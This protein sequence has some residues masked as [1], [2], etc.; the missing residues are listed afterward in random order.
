[1]FVGTA[2]TLAFF[3]ESVIIKRERTEPVADKDR[4]QDDKD[5]MQEW[6][7]AR[8]KLRWIAEGIMVAM[9]LATLAGCNDNMNMPSHDMSTE[10]E[11]Q[12]QVSEQIP[13][14][15]DTRLQ[16]EE[17][18]FPDQAWQK[19]VFFPD[20][21]GYVDN[22]LAMNGM[23]SFVGY[24]GQGSLYVTVAE[25]VTSFSMYV[26]HRE[27][28][29]D[30][31]T[32][33][34]S[35]RIDIADTVVN[36]RNTVQVAG[37]RPR[38][39]QSAVRVSVGYPEVLPG[40]PD[41]EGIA[42]ESLDLISDLIQSDIENGFTSAQLAVVRNGRLVY[43]NAWGS[44]NAY[45]P[46]GT[47]KTDSS[48]VTVDTLYDLASVTKMFSVNYALQKLV[49]DGAIGLDDCIADY[50]G[51]A[52][53]Q[54]VV[55]V[56]GSAGVDLATQKKWK[57]NLTIRELLQHQG[58]FPADPQ[59]FRPS[60][61]LFAGNDGSAETRAAT[62]RAICKTP[63]QY[64]P[65]TKTLYSDVDYM[66]LG[67]VVEKVTGQDLNTYLKE[68]FWEPM[69]LSHITYN[70]LQN[71]F[72]PDDCA[73]TELNGNSRDGYVQF[74][75]LRTETLQGQVHDEKAYYCMGGVSGHAGLFSNAS[76][77]AK[78]ASVMLTG[79]Y[80]GNRFF[81]QNVLDMFTSP[82][83]EDAANWGLGWWREGEDQRVWY[84]GT[85]SGS[86]TI[87]HQGWTGTV[88]MSDPDRSLVIVYLTNKINSP[89][90]DKENDPNKFN[91]S[92][93]TA[94]TLGFVPQILSV[95]MDV[96]TA[97][98]AEGQETAQAALHDQLSVLA[99]DMA[100]ESIKLLPDDV[101]VEHPAVKNVESKIALLAKWNEEDE[102]EEYRRLAAE[103][104]GEIAALKE[105]D[106]AAVER[107]LAVMTT[108]QKV[109]LMMVPALQT[110][111]TNDMADVTKRDQKLA[112]MLKEGAFGG[113][114]L[115]TQ[116]EENTVNT[117]NTENA[118]QTMKV[119]WSMRDWD[120]AEKAIDRMTMVKYFPVQKDVGTAGDAEFPTVDTSLE[121]LEAN[122]LSIFRNELRETDLILAEHIRYPQ[123]ETQTY[124]SRKNKEEITLPAS[125]S[126]TMINGLLRGEC[127]YGGV[128]MT[129][130]MNTPAIAAHFDQEDAAQ[131]AIEAGAD[132]LFMPVNVRTAKDVAE[133][134]RYI[135]RIVKM[136]EEGEISKE[137]MDESAR[138]ILMMK[139]RYGLLEETGAYTE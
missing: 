85:Q 42:K 115:I 106:M 101:W 90:T 16:A 95:G 125:L 94:S 111:E 131:L 33:G 26:N 92:Y 63:L 3:T 82:K 40:M 8:K 49:S 137:R 56:P 32:G 126:K 104:T 12:T 71:G 66:A 124:I 60:N 122:E 47:K 4:K 37:I 133:L 6:N 7:R 31:M 75:G 79:G 78:L 62:V 80:G 112:G 81:S 10:P 52:F 73:A 18:Q 36:G 109:M 39:A 128:V 22:T 97:G 103:L 77:L 44:T 27:V 93:Y 108:R 65:G 72:T 130:A 86:H 2:Q 53:Y 1:M 110:P 30:S 123:I 107:T 84:F 136:V 91:G 38:E 9:L 74:D 117:A 129:D 23:V 120:K 51:E 5:N 118:E 41:E 19:D 28:N 29:T 100:A 24:H 132:M 89:V 61:A 20:W 55:I 83:K 21:K 64:E 88:C 121:R 135:D 54:D 87:G 138:R 13:E 17:V 67:F 11:P 43:E 34:K 139:D 98:T 50:L 76:D 25:E 70:P 15:I 113:F 119:V 134:D 96:D 45:L 14:N 57:Q 105:P 114:A 102:A 48:P 35:Y 116:N 127:E 46:D 68:T 99:A 58:G 69:G 59:Y